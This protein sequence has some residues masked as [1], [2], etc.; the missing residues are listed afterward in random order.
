MLTPMIH[1]NPT[2]AIRPPSAR[3]CPREATNATVPW[4]EKGGTVR[5]VMG[6]NAGIPSWPDYSLVKV[7]KCFHLSESKREFKNR[8]KG[9][10][11]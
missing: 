3:R 5:K 4:D 11:E 8:R 7:S 2:G 1:A 9:R 10:K 6:L